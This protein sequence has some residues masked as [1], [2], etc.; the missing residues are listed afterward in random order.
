[1]EL[2]IDKSHKELTM[3]VIPKLNSTNVSYHTQLGVGVSISNSNIKS[4]RCKYCVENCKYG[5]DGDPNRDP[6]VHRTIIICEDYRL[7]SFLEEIF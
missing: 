1:M 3:N 4:S 7:P 5:K 2:H 6:N